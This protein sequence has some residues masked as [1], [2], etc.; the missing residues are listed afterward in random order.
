[1]NDK[2]M[3]EQAIENAKEVVDR[4]EEQHREL[5][6]CK[7]SDLI[8]LTDLVSKYQENGMT[9]REIRRKSR[10]FGSMELD[11]FKRMLKS[12]VGSGVLVVSTTNNV[13]GR[14]RVAYVAKEFSSI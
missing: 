6:G 8:T 5:Y 13:R 9:T 7:D 1:M 2:Q 11:A 10:F 14:P 12:L 3:L 4:L